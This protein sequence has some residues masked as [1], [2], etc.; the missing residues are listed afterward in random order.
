MSVADLADLAV[1]AAA[2]LLLTACGMGAT[3]TTHSSATGSSVNAGTPAVAGELR[4]VADHLAPPRPPRLQLEGTVLPLDAVVSA[5]TGS[6][7]EVAAPTAL[8]RWPEVTVRD[9]RLRG[10][11]T[12]AAAPERVVLQGFRSLDGQGLPVETTGREVLCTAE[13][14]PATCSLSPRGEDVSWEASL[15]GLDGAPYLT[16]QATWLRATPGAASPVAEYWCTYVVH[17][18]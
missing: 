3:G 12:A 9:G 8:P 5:W 13:S 18:R 2:A 10:V 11:L 14:G 15:A 7:D 4:P 16:V 17:A 6:P 1:V